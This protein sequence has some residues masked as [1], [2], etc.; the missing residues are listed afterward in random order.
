MANA[1]GYAMTE[2]TEYH[3]KVLTEYLGE[4]W[5]HKGNISVQGMKAYSCSKCGS[6]DRNRTFTTPA[7]IY[8]VYSRMVELGEWEEF[9]EYADEIWGRNP[10]LSKLWWE[11]ADDW[12]FPLLS[13]WLSCYGCPEQIPDRMKMAATFIEERRQ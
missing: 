1:K 8:A 4:C 10:I 13:S 9:C 12:Q 7:D 11:S 5:H 3:R 6:R 2:L